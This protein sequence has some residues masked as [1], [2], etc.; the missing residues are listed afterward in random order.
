MLY[1]KAKSI[2]KDRIKAQKACKMIFLVAK[3]V[4]LTIFLVKKA[5][6]FRISEKSNVLI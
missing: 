4:L 2:K 5:R 6:N 1:F 3:M